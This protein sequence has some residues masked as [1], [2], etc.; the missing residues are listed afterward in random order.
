MQGSVVIH[1]TITA[2][3]YFIPVKDIPQGLFP[4]MISEDD[5]IKQIKVVIE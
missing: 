5:F 2:K 1:Q 3:R 4:L